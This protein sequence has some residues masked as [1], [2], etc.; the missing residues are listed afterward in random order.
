MPRR[1]LRQPLV[2]SSTQRCA[3]HAKR[4]QK[5]CAH[6]DTE[7]IMGTD[8][9][10]LCPQGHV[11]SVV[12]YGMLLSQTQKDSIKTFYRRWT[13]K[14]KRGSRKRHNWRL[15]PNLRRS[16]AIELASDH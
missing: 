14:T 6:R 1:T 10:L 15:S 16:A 5:P 4:S 7:K 13:E 12:C 3:S 9:R 11:P 2:I 8:T